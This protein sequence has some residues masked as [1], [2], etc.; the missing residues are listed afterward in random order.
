MALTT[1]F[2]KRL[3][4]SPGIV[5]KRLLYSPGIAPPR[6]RS[7]AST[8][9]AILPTGKRVEEVLAA[10]LQAGIEH[11]R[12]V[13]TATLN[14]VLK[15]ATAWKAPPTQRHSLK[16]GKIYYCT[17]V[18]GHMGKSRGGSN[19]TGVCIARLL[20]KEAVVGDAAAAVF[21]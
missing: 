10:I 2:Y 19:G 5:Y 18:R 16:K 3:L 1:I 7:H 12:R 14:L 15:E 17:Q 21:A 13:S 6:V 9:V 8:F 11:R 20:A 4:Y